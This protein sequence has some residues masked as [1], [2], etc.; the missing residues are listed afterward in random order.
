[1]AQLCHI[2]KQTI[3]ALLRDYQSLSRW[4]KWFFPSKLKTALINYQDMPNNTTNARIACVSFVKDTWFF[5]KWIFSCLRMFS[6]SDLILACNSLNKANLLTGDLAQDNFNAVAGHQEPKAVAQTLDLLS[7]ANLLV[8]DSA[9]GNFNAVAWHQELGILALAL[10]ILSKANLLVGDSAQGNFN[11]V[12]GHQ[13]PNPV[14][15]ALF[16]LSRTN[17]LAG[18]SAQGNFNAVARHKNPVAVAQAL[19]DLSKA[20]LLA[21]DSAQGNFNTVA[22]H[23][24]PVEVFGALDILSRANLL[25]GDS[26]QDNFN[27]VARYPNLWVLPRTLYFLNKANLLTGDSA[28]GNFNAFARHPAVGDLC[29]VIKDLSIANLLAG[30]SAQGNFNAYITHQ[31]PWAVARA[32]GVLSRANLLAGDS[33]Q[34]NFNTVVRHQIPEYV[35]EALRLLTNTDFLADDSENLMADDS[36]QD[37]FNAVTWN[38]SDV[39]IYAPIQLFSDASA[40]NKINLSQLIA[41]T[42]VL[43]GNERT[44]EC[45]RRIPLGGFMQPGPLTQ[46]RIAAIFNLCRLHQA[47]EANARLAFVDYVDREVLQQDVVRHGAGTPVINGA[48]STHTASVHQSV[49]QSAINLLR[50]YGTSISGDRRDATIQGISDG[51]AQLPQNTPHIDVAIRCLQRLIADDY[52]FMDST[53][54]VSTKQLLA[55]AWIAIHD[56]T[57]RH[58][59][60]EDAKKCLIEGLYE[61]QRGYNLSEKNVDDGGEDAPICVAG[62]FNKLIEKLIGIHADV[63]II[64]V[65]PEMAAVK[66]PR[67]FREETVKYLTSHTNPGS[68]T[69]YLVA[70]R[71]MQQVKSEGAGFIWPEIKE[72]VRRRMFDDFG[73]LYRDNNDVRFLELIEA[74]IYVDLIGIPETFQES[75]LKSHGYRAYCS[76]VL[77]QQGIFSHPNRAQLAELLSENRNNSADDRRLFDMNFGLV[78]LERLQKK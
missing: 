43:L 8:G 47:D 16:L 33:G 67:V 77:T 13:E 17:L 31:N 28:Q 56:D 46:P 18:D 71:I 59:T 73:S 41:F 45:W 25:A 64:F 44:R 63:K 62:T 55:L 23:K 70:V 78:R 72:R 35:A 19:K 30:D 15:L 54:E 51:L 66:L 58:G 14:A 48:Q 69:E 11:T 12:A 7:K 50:A 60:L 6:G 29:E 4:E 39:A 10:Y 5:Q 21:G 42:P 52:F 2:N 26:A 68:L 74:G 24:N 3:D 37:I 27:A 34:G 49:S 9:Q 61:A 75:I 76:Y 57:K 53:S 40:L 36:A 22:R 32:L 1:M 65:T 20:N 38:R